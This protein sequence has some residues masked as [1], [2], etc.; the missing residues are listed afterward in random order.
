MIKAS[1][2]EG[3]DLYHK[4]CTKIWE[5]EKWPSD[6]KRAIFIPLP[7]KGDLKLCSN[8]RTI[9]LISHASKILLK[10]IMKRIENKLEQ[11]V[12]NTQAGFRKKRGTKDHI[13]NL[14]MIIQKYR[15][16]NTGLHTCF[17]DYSKAFD[18]VNHEKLWNTLNE[19]NF[20]H[21]TVNLIRSLYEEQQA[22]VRLEI[23]T[24][25]WFPVTKGVRQG[26]ILSP[27][28]FSLYTEGIMREV[29][30][31]PRNKLYA[32]P[33]IQ[34][35]PI[36][37]LRYADDTALLSA[38][39]T[40]LE[41]LIKSVKEHSE[42]KGLN[43]NIK[44]TKIMDTDKCKEEAIIKINGEEIER[45][46]SFEYLGAKIEANGKTTPEIRRRLAMATS[47]L[48]KMTNIW[49]GQCIETKIRVLKSTVFPTAT[50]GCETWSINKTD[51][52]KITAFEM[53]CYR[54]LLSIQWTER[55][56]NKEVL[57]KI[58]IGR[59]ILLQN[60]KK[61]KLGYF[62]HIKRHETLEKH[63]LEAKVEGK[64]GRGRPTRRW[65]QDIQE[66]LD[67]TIIEA[68]RLAT[69][70]LKFRKKIREATSWKGSAD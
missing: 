4:L 33:T 53:K 9:S 19:M 35:L 13:F 32:E 14:H 7:K 69:D 12:S 31:D 39:P 67:M 61:L 46:G 59:P 57:T 17:I 34:G 22:A 55:I 26:C 66:W 56:T 10:V 3:I 37:D 58:G 28:L 65:E 16:V 64:R 41:S 11:E 68:G 42:Q 51:A 50:Y 40:G 60:V 23:G 20:H 29:E 54:K 45:V 52:K 1:G 21:K 48:K 47:K 63:I 24:T 49:K 70:R 6:W 18:C 5:A 25:E 43:L 30:H 44:K 36:R 27:H 62:G 38:T 15:E 2:E 8:Y